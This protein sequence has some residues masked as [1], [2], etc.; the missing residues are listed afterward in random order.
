MTA[1]RRPLPRPDDV[2]PVV[3]YLGLLAYL[4]G[5]AMFIRLS[6]TTRIGYAVAA[7]VAVLTPL[8]LLLVGRPAPPRALRVAWIVAAA[9]AAYLLPTA[10]LPDGRSLV[11]VVVDFS[12]FLVPM[13][14]LLIGSAVPDTFR[15]ILG[16]RWVLVFL[17]ASLSSPLLVI[18]TAPAR[19]FD[20]PDVGVIALLATVAV[21]RPDER[22]G[23][24]AAVGSSLLIGLAAWSGSRSVFAIAVLAFV[25]VLVANRTARVL[26]V[27]A[28][29][30]GLVLSLVQLDV[31]A[32][33]RAG[34]P[35]RSSAR[36]VQMLRLG[37]GDVSTGR[38]NEAGM[39]LQDIRSRGPL[40]A[41]IG[42]GHGAVFEPESWWQERTIS[43]GGF[44]HNVHIGPLL[45]LFRYGLIGLVL[46]F[47]VAASAVTT[48]LRSL[49][50]RT[51]GID[52][53]KLLYAAGTALFAVDFLVRNVLPNPV[54]SFFLA[55]HIATTWIVE[56]TPEDAAGD[57]ASTLGGGVQSDDA[58]AQP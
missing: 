12:T 24:V 3:V 15:R 18:D 41:A 11:H 6:A 48:A 55:G 10:A 38:I 26:V 4:L 21:T 32:D 19:S 53:T 5:N 49:R 22:A 58:A 9:S 56:S 13:G 31:V 2:V 34:I 44:V 7:G 25:V 45:M 47:A 23:R 40:G 8:A 16:L 29:A 1:G 27:L 37:G 36:I 28:I 52:A 51:S 54:F 43:A 57:P 39:V 33:L 30:A 35:T 20:P 14:F 46:Y 50:R 17:L 42:L